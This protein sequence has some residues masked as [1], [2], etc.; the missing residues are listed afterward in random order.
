MQQDRWTDV[1]L[2]EAPRSTPSVSAE[3]MRRAVGRDPAAFGEVYEAHLGRIYRHVRYRIADADLA[4]DI[5]SQVFLRAWQAIARYE[6]REGRPFLAWLFTI[7]NNL[8]IDHHR[9]AK[10]E[11]TG[12]DADRHTSHTDDPE[13][14]AINTDLHDQIRAAISRLKPEY[15]LIVSLRLIEDME[16]E[17]IAR[18]I[19]KK[20]GA[21]RVTLF[22]ALNQ[23]R[24]DLSARGLRP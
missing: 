12:I 4:E 21:L 2:V 13:A 14:S 17:D 3:V 5:T 16:Y 23:L 8:I 20:P 6:P 24:D 22:R 10:R 11:F 9:R 7:A 15:Q 1:T 19:G 18:I